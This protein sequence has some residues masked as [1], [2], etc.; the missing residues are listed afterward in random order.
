LSK[1]GYDD[2]GDLLFRGRVEF[3][4]TPTDREELERALGPLT[5]SSSPFSKRRRKLQGVHVEPVLTAEIRYLEQTS[6]GLLGHATLRQLG[7]RWKH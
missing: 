2:V 7:G 6:D 4:I 3:G 5:R 1:G